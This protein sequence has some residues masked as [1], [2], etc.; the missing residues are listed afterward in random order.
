MWGIYNKPQSRKLNSEKPQRTI[1]IFISNFLNGFMGTF[2]FFKS[3]HC[4]A[5]NGLSSTSLMKFVL[6][7]P[8]A[9]TDVL[10]TGT[11]LISLV[12]FKLHFSGLRLSESQIWASLYWLVLRCSFGFCCVF[13]QPSVLPVPSSP[14]SSLSLTRSISYYSHHFLINNHPRCS[15]SVLFTPLLITISSSAPCSWQPARYP[16]PPCVFFT[17][18]FL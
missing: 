2:I 11:K 10:R 15:C 17:S 8:Q 16:G 14:S 4:F 7:V 3:V 13:I 1:T 12:R 9:V 18:W 6:E 5:L